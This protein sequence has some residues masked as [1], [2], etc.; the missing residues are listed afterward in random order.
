MK[1]NRLLLRLRILLKTERF[2]LILSLSTDNHLLLL[3]L[4]GLASTVS[5]RSDSRHVSVPRTMF[6]SMYTRHCYRW[7]PVSTAVA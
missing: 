1:N 2:L 7:H 4:V 6:R 5:L 3:S